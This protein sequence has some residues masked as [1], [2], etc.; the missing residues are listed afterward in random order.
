MRDFDVAFC[1]LACCRVDDLAVSV[2]ALD[3][4]GI[5][6][7]WRSVNHPDTHQHL[8]AIEFA[9]A[10]ELRG[11]LEKF[12]YSNRP[13]HDDRDRAILAPPYLFELKRAVNTVVVFRNNESEN[14]SR[15]VADSEDSSAN[16]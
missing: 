13:Q 14:T 2:L 5:V 11:M 4:E 1:E 3:C 9:D 8:V 10:T 7:V 12:S 6:A 15:V 16:S